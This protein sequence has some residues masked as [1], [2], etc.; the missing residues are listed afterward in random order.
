MA[1]SHHDV[2]QKQKC[3]FWFLFFGLVVGLA[4]TLSLEPFE[5]SQS[6]DEDVTNATTA[7]PAPT[8]E[9]ENIAHVEEEIKRMKHEIRSWSRFS[10]G[11][12]F[13]SM[14]TFLLFLFDCSKQDKVLIEIISALDQE[15]KE[16]NGLKRS[17]KELNEKIV[18]IK[19]DVLDDLEAN[20]FGKKAL[21]PEALQQSQLV[22]NPNQAAWM[23][24]EDGDSLGS[25]PGIRYY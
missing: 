8:E 15:T 23:V 18:T 9:S 4:V 19:V 1:V 24:P 16:R 20:L 7:T 6:E 10:I 3:Q 14:M 13:L 17:V 2:K 5:L 21:K 22:L 11:I 25:L 12:G